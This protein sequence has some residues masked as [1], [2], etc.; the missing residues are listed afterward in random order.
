MR[1]P[2]PRL[3]QWQSCP[4]SWE[5]ACRPTNRK[6]ETPRPCLQRSTVALRSAADTEAAAGEGRLDTSLAQLAATLDPL[7][8]AAA[9]RLEALELAV[10]VLQAGMLCPC[11]AAAL[12]LGPHAPAV[13]LH[14]CR[15]PPFTCA[16]QPSITHF[17]IPALQ[18]AA[19]SLADVQVAGGSQEMAEAEEEEDEAAAMDTTD[20][21]AIE[22][23]AALRSLASLLQLEDAAA[24]TSAAALAAAVHARVAELLMQLPA[25][26]FEPLLPP[27][28]LDDAQ[29]WAVSVRG[30]HKGTPC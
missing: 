14:R 4:K 24:V 19:L 10:G 26:F 15:P 2:A 12:L 20:E 27:D 5:G 28:S 17:N 9:S 16:C 22:L 23:S 6:P 7:L 30:A 18:A 11:W 8:G 21:M 1:A 3:V 25:G 13:H 29:V